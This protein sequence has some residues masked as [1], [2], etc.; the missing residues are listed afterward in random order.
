MKRHEECA[1]TGDA[2]G[3]LAN[4]VMAWNTAQMQAAYDRLSARE[5]TTVPPELIR[6]IAPTRTEGMNLRDVFRFPVDTDAE[7][8]LPSASRKVTTPA[9]A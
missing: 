8:L 9:G 3:L 6:R 2:L 7:R 1:A 4:L 5:S